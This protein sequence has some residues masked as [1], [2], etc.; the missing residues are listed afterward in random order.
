[1]G[2]KRLDLSGQV[3]G[4]LTVTGRDGDNPRMWDCVCECGK[5]CKVNAVRIRNGKPK[6]CGCLKSEARSRAASKH[7]ACVNGKNSPTYQSYVAM[8]HRCYNS[9]RN[10]WHRYG[11]RGIIV[12]E[13][14]WLEESPNGYLNFLRDMGERPDGTSLDRIDGDGNYCKDNCRWVD[15]SRQAYNREITKS[16]KNTSRFRGVSLR[17]RAGFCTYVARI[18]DGVGG[19]KWLGDFQTEEEAALAYNT[20]AISMYGEDAILNNV[21]RVVYEEDYRDTRGVDFLRKHSVFVEKYEDE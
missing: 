6:S 2:T 10:G 15:R 1:M 20:E 18:G 16:D 17:S 19:Y 14:S 9:N 11:G 3:F 7:G 21:S 8:K 4:K 13:L 5:T 12:S